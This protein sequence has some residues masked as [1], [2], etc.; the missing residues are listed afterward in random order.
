MSPLVSTQALE[1]AARLDVRAGRAAGGRGQGVRASSVAGVGTVFLDHRTY[2]PGDDLR[3]V[4]WNAY[5]RL[6]ALHVKVHELEENLDLHLL[7]DRTASMGEGEASK[8]R[9]ACRV[10]ALV[11]A[12]ALARGDTVRLQLLPSDVGQRRESGQ[13]AF[14]GRA[15]TPRLLAA[16]DGVRSGIRAPLGRVLRDAFPRLRR[17]G[18]AL[19]LTDFLDEPTP[20]VA[21]ERERGW[22]HAVDFL[23]FRRVALTAVHVVAP[24][25]RDP[26]LQGPVRLVDAETGVTVDLEVTAALLATY[27]RRFVRGVREVAAYLR[28]KESRHMLVDTAASDEDGLLRTL[29]R[30]GVL[31]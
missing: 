9:A 27:R 14:R 2:A 25:E 4:D 22:R 6:R 12:A 17:R 7:L 3:Y 10:A 30:E 18:Y 11:G 15:E 21:E 1:R 24:E 26:V 29:L 16:L 20:G 5:G 23:A 13:R 8:L 31:A 28:S 19:L